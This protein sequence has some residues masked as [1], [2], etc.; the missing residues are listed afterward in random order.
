MGGVGRRAKPARKAMRARQTEANSIIRALPIE[1]DSPT[2]SFVLENWYLFVA[3]LVSGALLL[4]PMLARRRR[5]RGSAPPTRCSL[6]NREKA[7]LIDV[8]EPAEYAAGHAVGAQNVPLGSLETLARAAEE[9]VAAA[10]RRLPDRRA[11]AAR[12]RRR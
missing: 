5:R 7:V 9:Q 2:L 12:R 4:W 1:L 10:G 11:R 6:I 3:A 8:S